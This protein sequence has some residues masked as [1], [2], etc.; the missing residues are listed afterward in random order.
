MEREVIWLPS[1]DQLRDHLGLT[2]RS[3]TRDGRR[4]TCAVEAVGEER[5]YEAASASDAYGLALLDLI[6]ADPDVFPRLILDEL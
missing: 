4:Y 2:F 3:L 5:T 6:Q 1:E